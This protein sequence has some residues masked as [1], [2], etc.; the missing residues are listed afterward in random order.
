MY[1]KVNINKPLHDLQRNIVPFQQFACK[2][3]KDKQVYYVSNF[4]LND[5][6]VN[7]RNDKS[8]KKIWLKS[9]NIKKFIIL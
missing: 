1:R 8:A 2:Y 9:V 5:T 6:S 3:R 4:K 7:E